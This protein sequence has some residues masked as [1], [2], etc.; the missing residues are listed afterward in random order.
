MTAVLAR[1]PVATIEGFSRMSP[2]DQAFVVDAFDR[3]EPRQQKFFL[4]Y[5]LDFNA[6]QAAVRAKYSKR[7]AQE[8]SSRLLLK[9]GHV[10]A[11][12]M[13]A[14]QN[15]LAEKGVLSRDRWLLEIQR[16][17]L[18]D[19]RKLYDNH[20]N[21]REI[22]ELDDESA[23]AIAGFEF[24]EEYEGRGESR[25]ATGVTKKFK[26]ADKLRALE[27]YG[28]AVGHYLGDSKPTSPLEEAATGLLLEM[29][30]HLQ[31]KRQALVSA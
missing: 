27:L 28:K 4:E 3:L 29:R 9:V 22:P 1:S 20:G 19:V 6:T 31:A 12:L 7:T 8:Q 14:Q 21:P 2:E 23:A 30:Q 24:L 5:F 13:R 15:V 17:A 16:I 10:L 11:P 25:Q 26:L 18:F